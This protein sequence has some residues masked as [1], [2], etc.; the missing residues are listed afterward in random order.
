MRFR[1]NEIGDE[2]LALNLALGADWLKAECPDLEATVGKGGL[3]FQGKL[4]Q[5]GDD[6]FLRGSLRGTL[7]CT[8]ARCL[9]PARL[10][11][12]LPLNVTF[13]ARADSRAEDGA[14]DDDDED[15][16]VVPFDGDE[17]DVGP[18]LREQI[19]LSFPINPLCRESCAGLCP[20]C[21]GNRNQVACDCAT[22]QETPRTP[23][24]AA[25]GKLKM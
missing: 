20:F 18:Q 15:V 3:T 17:I 22:R 25:L 16:D 6:A 14:D 23:L 1:I 10:P 12:D 8:C 7:A 2:G 5:D 24:A 11:L 21:G 19:L 4:S 13:V 9:E